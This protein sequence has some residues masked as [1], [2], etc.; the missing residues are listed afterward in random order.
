MKCVLAT[1]TLFLAMSNALAQGPNAGMQGRTVKALS[2]QQVAD[3]SQRR[4]MGMALAAELNGYPGPSRVL[5]LADR[6]VETESDFRGTKSVRIHEARVDP[7]GRAV[8]RRKQKSIGNSRRGPPLRT[9]SARPPLSPKA[10]FGKPI[11]DITCPR[12]RSWSWSR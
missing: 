7:V 10:N 8:D 4:G 2:D 6:L 3:L 5:E 11:L 1:A 12:P 9:V